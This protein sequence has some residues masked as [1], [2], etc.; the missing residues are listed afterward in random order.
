MSW[1]A[2]AS[3]LEYLYYNPSSYSVE[4]AWRRDD[5]AARAAHGLLA[6]S[7]R[8]AFRSQIGQRDGVPR[9]SQLHVPSLPPSDRTI[10]DTASRVVS[11]EQNSR[12]RV[13][14]IV[15]QFPSQ[16]VPL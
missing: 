12:S 9:Q 2:D 4:T 1:L 6:R 10:F 7:P 8:V 11:A 13:F 16:H 15:V 5:P 14:T 3:Y